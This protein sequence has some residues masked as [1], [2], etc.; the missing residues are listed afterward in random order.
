[1]LHPVQGARETVELESNEVPAA[2]RSGH[3]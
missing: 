2:G 1:V 3:I